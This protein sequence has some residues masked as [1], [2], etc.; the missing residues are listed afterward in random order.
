MKP[1][2]LPPLSATM[3]VRPTGW[4]SGV[5]LWLP[6]FLVWLLLLPL[7]L[8]ALPVLFVASLIF[9]VKLW[10]SL[11]AANALLAATRG[12]EVEVDKPD[13]R[14]FIKVHGKEIP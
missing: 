5:K 3:H 9:R 11:K 1:E 10:R 2:I 7:V 6:L 12:T 8:L 14:V 13:V 4:R